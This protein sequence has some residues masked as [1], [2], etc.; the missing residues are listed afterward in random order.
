VLVG[1]ELVDR[2]PATQRRAQDAARAGAHD[3]VE[4]AERAA[5]AGFEGGE[6]TGSPGR[7]EDA[8]GPEHESGPASASRHGGLLVE[9][10]TER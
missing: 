8:P 2:H 5:D 9:R 3:Q 7:P 10:P 4:G 1:D 6:R